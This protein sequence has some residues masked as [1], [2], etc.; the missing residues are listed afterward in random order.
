MCL[1][2]L[3]LI[4]IWKHWVL[5]GGKT[6]VLG[7][8]PLKAGKGTNNKLK[9]EKLRNIYAAVSNYSQTPKGVIEC[10]CFNGVSILG[11]L[12]LKK[13]WGFLSPGT[14]QKFCL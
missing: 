9:K 1:C 3:N 13:M 7:E 2:L 10:V 11:R 5:A 6:R 14:K 12:N 8:K 4:G